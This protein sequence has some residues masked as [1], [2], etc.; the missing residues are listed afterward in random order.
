MT[1]L[2]RWEP[3]LGDFDTLA[4]RFNQLFDRSWPLAMG[5]MVTE[6]TLAW[7]PAVDIYDEGEA[8]SLEAELPGYRKEDIDVRVENGVLFITGERQRSE[9]RSGRKRSYVRSERSFGRFTRSFSLPSEVDSGR[10]EAAYRDGV[11][12]VTLPKTE[13]SRPR[14]IDVRIN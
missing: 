14:E 13:A 8:L 2:V 10:I 6:P 5:H 3:F 7:V 4:G 12:T 11:L 9:P 1:G